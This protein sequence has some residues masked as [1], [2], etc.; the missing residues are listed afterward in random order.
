MRTRSSSNLFS[1]SLGVVASTLALAALT[2][3]GTGGSSGNGG[4]GPLPSGAPGP[5]PSPLLLLPPAGSIYLGVFVNPSQTPSPP[6]S[7][8]AG[9]EAQIG[10]KMGISTHYYGFYDAFPGPYEIDDVANGRIPVDSWDCE[11]SNA[12]VASGADDNAIRSKAD[13][14]KAFGHPIFL[15]YMWEMNLPATP[16]FRHVCYDPVNDLP[17]GV[18]S[19]QNYIAA[20]DHIREIFAEENVTNVVWVWNPSG[21]KNP[22]PYYPGASETDWIG[23]DRYDDGN[24]SVQATYAQPYAWLAPLGKPIMI[25]E[26]GATQTQQPSFF[27]ENPNG[28]AAMLRNA[29]PMVKAYMYF[30][31]A[32]LNFAGSYSWVISPN[33][34]AAFAAMAADPYFSAM[35]Q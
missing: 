5:T 35:L 14:I 20:W 34:I 6:P 16:T 32:N 23:F 3:C 24:V 10:R 12:A 27:A 17:N 11:P 2:C 28:A 30:D 1:L 18:F 25:G 8:L 22:L 4:R 21:A 26:T 13:A 29:F 31:S 7:L 33:N 9:F 15:R 19:P